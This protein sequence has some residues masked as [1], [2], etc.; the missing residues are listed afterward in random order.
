MFHDGPWTPTKP[1]LPHSLTTPGLWAVCRGFDHMTTRES[2]AL[3]MTTLA[4]VWWHTSLGYELMQTIH[5]WHIYT[6][7]IKINQLQVN[8][9]YILLV[10]YRH[11]QCPT[12]NPPLTEICVE[13]K[14][15][16]NGYGLIP[17]NQVKVLYI[18]PGK[19]TCYMLP[20]G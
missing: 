11:G 18:T 15:T 14:W 1:S 13:V 6:R 2:K 17:F 5:V 7:I 12:V 9:P 4:H 19:F 3:V 20:I 16:S 8:M 10:R